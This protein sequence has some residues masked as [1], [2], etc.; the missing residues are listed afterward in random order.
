[1]NSVSS[2]LLSKILLEKED[3]DMLINADNVLGLNVTSEDII[4]YLE[5]TTTDQVITSPIIGHSIITEG[6]ILSILKVVLS[7]SKYEGTYK[8]FINEDNMGTNAYL[9]SR[10]NNCYKDLNL[11][12][13]IDLDFSENYNKYVN[14]MVTLVGSKDFIETASKDFNNPNQIII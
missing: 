3:F 13:D 7:L 5:F 6:D 4:N 8:L 12:V 9:V 2:N 11:N 14:E 1:M 10:A